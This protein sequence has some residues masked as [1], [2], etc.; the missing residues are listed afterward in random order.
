MAKKKKKNKELN[1]A[2]DNTEMSI[3]LE[4]KEISNELEEGEDV[5]EGAVEITSNSPIEENVKKSEENIQE[6]K[7]ELP[8]ECVHIFK[9]LP[10]IKYKKN[11]KG[12][13]HTYKTFVCEKCG[14]SE[15]RKVR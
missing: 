14:F 5:S 7:E 2:I 15:E 6:E 8:K 9:A 4:E 1:I 13:P 10:A 12:I 3:N 11:A